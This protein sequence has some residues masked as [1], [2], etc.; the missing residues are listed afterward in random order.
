MSPRTTADRRTPAGAGDGVIG[1][2]ADR[3]NRY[4]FDEHGRARR[5]RMLVTVLAM[6]VLALSGSLLFVVMALVG[7]EPAARA[8]VDS[9]VCRRCSSFR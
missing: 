9:G 3:L 6:V 2:M 7:P 8:R 1:T 5:P 4:L